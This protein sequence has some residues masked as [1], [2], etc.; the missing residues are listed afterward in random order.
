MHIVTKRERNLAL[1]KEAVQWRRQ[2]VSHVNNVPLADKWQGVS[3]NTVFD[4]QTRQLQGHRAGA[5]RRSPVGHQS[6]EAILPATIVHVKPASENNRKAEVLLK[7][8]SLN[9]QLQ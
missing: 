1:A 2:Q 5:S 9:G 4:L 3:R 8:A 7:C 6:H